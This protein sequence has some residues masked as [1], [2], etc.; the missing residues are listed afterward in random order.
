MNTDEKVYRLVS[1]EEIELFQAL[2]EVQEMRGQISISCTPIDWTI[3]ATSVQLVLT[4]PGLSEECKNLLR[5]WLCTV[6]TALNSPVVN[7]T[8]ELTDKLQRQNQELAEAMASDQV[9]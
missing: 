1:M 6:K 5:Q 4:H 9:M 8:L 7:K 3:V 2:R